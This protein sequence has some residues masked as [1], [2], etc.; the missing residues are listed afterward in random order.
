[1]NT[2]LLS[3][4][5]ALINLCAKSLIVNELGELEASKLNLNEIQQL[6]L[7]ESLTIKELYSNMLLKAKNKDLADRLSLPDERNY[8]KVL[9]EIG[10]PSFPEDNIMGILSYLLND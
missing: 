9:N 10:S 2:G 6:L 8:F 1:M 4:K 5:I 3:D 7:K